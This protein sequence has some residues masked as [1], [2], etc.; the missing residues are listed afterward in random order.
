MEKFALLST[1]TS[2]DS[3]E[4]Y[5]NPPSGNFRFELAGVFK[6]FKEAAE[7]AAKTI[8]LYYIPGLS[9]DEIL[10][11]LEKG[12][13]IS[14]QGWPGSGQNGEL[15]CELFNTEYHPGKEDDRIIWVGIEG[16]SGPSLGM[17]IQ[18]IKG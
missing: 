9:L 16:T 17:R 3:L 5:Q 2:E 18:K 4:L 13:H 8:A 15:S 6:T 12:G 11:V 1:V 7:N 14:G 10:S